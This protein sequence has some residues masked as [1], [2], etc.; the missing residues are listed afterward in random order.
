MLLSLTDLPS[1][2]LLIGETRAASSDGGILPVLN[3]ATGQTLAE[4][5]AGTAADI[6]RAVQAA[7]VAYPEWRRRGPGGRAEALRSLAATVRGH[8]ESLALLECR[9]VGKPIGDARWEIGYVARVLEFYAGA[10]SVAGGAIP[11]VSASGTGLTFREPLGVCG[12][13]VPWNF[14][15]V[16]LAWKLG[17]ALCMGNTVVVKPA[18][19][20]PLSALR[21]GELALEAGLPP[22]VVNV[23]P[24]LGAVA[25]AALATHP[26]V[27]K[28]SFT[29]STRTGREVMRAAADGIKRVS[30]E[31][32]G[33]SASIVF[34][35]ADL[36]KAAASTMS[37]FANTGQDCCARSRYLIERTIYDEFVERFVANTRAAK[38]GNP[39]SSDT[40][41]GPLVHPVHFER[42][43]G[44]VEAGRRE[45]A[46]LVCGGGP[47]E[48]LDLAGGCWFAPTVFDRVSPEMTIA[49]EEIF[50]PVV[51]MIPF[52]TEDEALRIANGTRY[53][54]SG[55]VW[56]RDVA[57]ALRASRALETGAIS[58]NCSSSVHLEMP[59]GGFKESGIGREL[60]LQAL[61]HY[62]EWKSVFISAE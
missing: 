51:S 13:I 8:A 12:L 1:S 60:G 56:T 35:D 6:G 15:L 36:E 10:A 9:N 43:A 31:L 29:G 33:K 20:T 4:V 50:G 3:P 58:V 32:G 47:P 14:P 19:W 55:S 59:F 61:D 26:G 57:R 39:E 30:L 11:P 24:G 16:I 25:G 28:V 44:F 62:S 23:V 22:G 38:V 41:L 17:P 2:G 40:E 45:G 46:R 52:G 49:Q 37:V 54:L 27:R 21:L 53:G 34:A 5:A 48:R 42:V 18:E 7:S